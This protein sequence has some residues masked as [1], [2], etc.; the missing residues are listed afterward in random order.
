[1]SEFLMMG[2]YAAY[3]WPSMGLGLLVLLF[4]II[5]P[6]FSHRSA[7]KKADDYHATVKDSIGE[8]Q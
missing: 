8:Q 4:N 7:L 5:V 6:I 1:M 3:V 2:G